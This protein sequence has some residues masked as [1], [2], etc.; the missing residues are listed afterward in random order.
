MEAEQ[1]LKKNFTIISVEGNSNMHHDRME[2][3]AGC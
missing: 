2:S 3:N 1:I